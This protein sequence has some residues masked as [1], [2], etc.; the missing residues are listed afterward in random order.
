M[1]NENVYANEQSIAYSNHL[2][3]KVKLTRLRLSPQGRETIIS[4]QKAF[5]TQM[6]VNDSKPNNF[7]LRSRTFA[8]TEGLRRAQKLC[9]HR[10]F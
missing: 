9:I 4:I 10:K 1:A 5:L 8:Q 6:N 7:T 2:N 3:N